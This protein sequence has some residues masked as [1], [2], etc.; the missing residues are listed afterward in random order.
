LAVI[1]L[2]KVRKRFVL[3]PRPNRGARTVEA[4]RD[5]TLSIPRGSTCGVVGP[6]GA[7]K[8]TLFALILGFLKPSTGKVRLDGAAPRTFMRSQGAGYLPERF[9]LPP[10]W[11]VEATLRALGNL[12]RLSDPAARASAVIDDFG[13]AEH[14]AKP[15]GTLSRGL[16]QRVG[17]AQALLAKRDLVV[18]DE[19]TEGLDPLWRLRLREQINNLRAEGRTLLIASHDLA[20]VERLVERVIVLEDGRVRDDFAVKSET[21]AVRRYRLNLQKPVDTMEQ[22]FPGHQRIN[23]ENG[24]I[25][26]VADADDLNARLAALL[27]AGGV[28]ESLIPADGVEQRVR[29]V[30]APKKRP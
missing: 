2:E 30:L 9:S 21:A 18:L 26:S 15:L 3:P 28:V 20:E 6:N 4:L 29:D 19:P 12:D 8:S 22:I 13:L 11:T 7:G 14:L 16:L 5:I 25:V 10:E 24:V 27:A 1:E 23:G 17:I